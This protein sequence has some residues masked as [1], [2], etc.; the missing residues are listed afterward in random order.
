MLSLYAVVILGTVMQYVKFIIL[1]QELC[2]VTHYIYIYTANVIICS[3][4]VYNME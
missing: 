2:F 1:V 3:Q 4:T